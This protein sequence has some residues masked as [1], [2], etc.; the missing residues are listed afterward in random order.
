LQALRRGPFSC[1]AVLQI[2][3]FVFN[4]SQILAGAPG[5]TPCNMRPQDLRGISG[6]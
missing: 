5:D 6:A 3:P 1:C 4:D 2:F